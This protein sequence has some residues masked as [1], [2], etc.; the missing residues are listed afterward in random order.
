MKKIN[1]IGYGNWGKKIYPILKNI[2]NTKINIIKKKDIL[3][4]S[5]LDLI[6]TNNETHYSLV[7]KSLMVN[8]NVFCEKPL[9]T[10]T[11]KAL[12]LYKFSDV[13]KKKIYVSD[14]ENFKNIKIKIKEINNIVRTKNSLIKDDILWRFAYHDLSYLYKHVKYKK[15]TNI[16]I[17]KS[18]TGIM[19]FNLIFNDIK[20]NFYYNLNTK[21][22]KHFFN[23]TNLVSPND[24]Y[25]K[26]IN[27]LLLRKVDFIQNKK[28][29]LFCIKIIEKIFK[30]NKKTN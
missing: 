6:I 20:F 7:K 11:L 27:N 8:N 25:A 28:I 21:I 10:S 9:T 24:F 22:K 23:D 18:E 16:K 15:L 4:K 14:I 17:I 2:K 13:T 30:I 29:S 19:N 3:N 26:M 5:S 1:L 12:K